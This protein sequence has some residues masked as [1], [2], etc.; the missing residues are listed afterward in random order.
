MATDDIQPLNSSQGGHVRMSAFERE[1]SATHLSGEWVDVN[2]SGVV[3]A[4]ADGAAAYDGTVHYI[5]ADDGTITID[6]AGD[7]RYVDGPNTAKLDA[8]YV[9]TKDTE[10]RTAGLYNNS[11]TLVTPLVTHIG[12]TCGTYVTAAGVS[13]VDL[14]TGGLKIVR[15]LDAQNTDISLSGNAGTQV[16]F[17]LDG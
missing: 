3:N 5:A 7:A 4:L 16:V 13:G 14:N 6:R 9:I 17:T 12:D 1:A 8:V 15:V 11:D 10:F 2:A